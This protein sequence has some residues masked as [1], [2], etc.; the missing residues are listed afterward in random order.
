MLQKIFG[1][2]SRLWK[3]IMGL[4]FQMG[5]NTLMIF[6]AW[7]SRSHFCK[8]EQNP[9]LT[10]FGI[11]CFAYITKFESSE[12][13]IQFSYS[14]SC[15][16]KLW[17]DMFVACM[18]W[19]MLS[20][21]YAWLSNFIAWLS[22]IITSWCIYKVML[23]NFGCEKRTMDNINNKKINQSTDHFVV[24]WNHWSIN[25]SMNH[26]EFYCWLGVGTWLGG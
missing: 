6:H 2:F 26:W 1:R 15:Y 19:C 7:V 14:D 21:F 20:T 5:P 23:W 9:V 17:E 11:I 16:Y 22:V 18:C 12:K 24:P 25:Q 4:F 3:A 10:G 13:A 8:G